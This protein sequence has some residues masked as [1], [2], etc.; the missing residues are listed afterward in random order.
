MRESGG[1]C[2]ETFRCF[3]KECRCILQDRSR[4]QYYC[5]RS[6]VIMIK[7]SPEERAKKAH[8]LFEIGYNCAQAVAMS[9]SDV[10]QMDEILISKLRL[11]SSILLYPFLL[12]QCVLLDFSLSSIFCS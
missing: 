3:R 7:I 6:I 8:E 2:F 9:F 4:C 10:I 5:L 1:E 12:I 11:H